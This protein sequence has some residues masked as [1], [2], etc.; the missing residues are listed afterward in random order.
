LFQALFIGWK[1]FLTFAKT[2]YD[3]R[4]PKL[5]RERQLR[6][7]YRFPGFV[8]AATVRGVFGKPR[9]RVLLLHRRQKK[10]SAAFAAGDSGAITIRSFVWSATCRVVDTTSIWNCLCDG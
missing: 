5:L 9:V 10:Q 7:A 3:W 1:W 2:G 8:P 4:M 6:D